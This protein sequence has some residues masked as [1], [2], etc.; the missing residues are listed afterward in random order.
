M[1]DPDLDERLRVPNWATFVES[2][3]EEEYPDITDEE[4]PENQS[5]LFTK[6]TLPLLPTESTKRN[7]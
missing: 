1:Q 5:T 6:I 3:V 4:K 2:V 7:S